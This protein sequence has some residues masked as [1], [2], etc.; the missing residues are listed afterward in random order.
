ML[1]CKEIPGMVD[2]CS[3]WHTSGNNIGLKQYVVNQDE[4]I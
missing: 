4:A 3:N 2:P 1:V